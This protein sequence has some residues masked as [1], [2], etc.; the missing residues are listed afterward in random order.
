MDASLKQ[1]VALSLALCAAA[2]SLA[3]DR[4]SGE[5]ALPLARLDEAQGVYRGLEV[6]GPC[7]Q[8]TSFWIEREN[9][10]L[11]E[12]WLEGMDRFD[13]IDEKPSEPQIWPYLDRARSEAPNKIVV[14]FNEEFA[15]MGTQG[16]ATFEFG[17][18]ETAYLLRVEVWAF[19]YGFRVPVPGSYQRWSCSYSRAK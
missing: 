17:E 4:F 15:G 3:A 14:D 11:R 1:V 16:Q 9:G 2:P 10:R 5:Q 6:A 8:A 18:T 7:P 19:G 13:G 12:I